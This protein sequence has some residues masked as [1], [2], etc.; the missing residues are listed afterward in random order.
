M[1]MNR[2]RGFG[3]TNTGGTKDKRPEDL[4]EML[5][6]T[7][8]FVQLRLIGGVYGY[9][10]RWIDIETKKGIISI[11][12]VALNYDPETDSYDSTLEDPYAKI[13]NPQR[14]SKSY[15]VNCI[16]RDL[17]DDKPRKLPEVSRDERRSGLKSKESKSWTPVRVLRVPAGAADS[18]KKLMQMN[19]HR[20]DGKIQEMEL[21]DE[22]YGMDLYISYDPNA[23]G[24][25]KYNVQKGDASPLTE[26]EKKYLI[27]DIS[28]LMSPE[29]LEEARKEAEALQ[30]KAPQEE[31]EE[32]EEEDDLPKR[33]RP[34]RTTEKPSRTTEK[35]ARSH[36]ASR[37]ADEPAAHTGRVKRTI[38]R[39]L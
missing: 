19:K 33:K 4:V 29:T 11:P 28:E 15:F 30:S 38:R 35:P 3:Q 7:A 2:T 23:A 18:I 16:V 10:Q 1:A 24:T 21:S 27:W 5:K 26:E 12:K 31:E 37:S 36:R 13:K 32:E 34:S 39:G 8:D 17:Q 6:P 25:A 20:V 22:K 9:A 14:V